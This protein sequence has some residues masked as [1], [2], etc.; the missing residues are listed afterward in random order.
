MRDAAEPQVIY[1]CSAI[2]FS[3]NYSSKSFAGHFQ[4]DCSSFSSDCFVA[5]G[6]GVLSWSCDKS[7]SGDTYGR[8]KFSGKIFIGVEING[9]PQVL[10]SRFCLSH[11]GESPALSSSGPVQRPVSKSSVPCGSPGQFS[12]GLSL[13]AM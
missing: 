4:L 2:S 5:G 12:P 8:I 1:L 11:C 10:I 13:L 3:V 6:N 7:I 9:C